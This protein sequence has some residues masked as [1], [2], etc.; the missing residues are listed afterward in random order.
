MAN[1]NNLVVVSDLHIGCKLGLC[2]PDG[3]EMDEGGQYAPS[4]VQRIVYTYWD[5]FWGKWVPDQVQGQD[6]DVL[7]NGDAINGTPH[8]AVSNWTNNREFQRRHAEKILGP[9]AERARR[10]FMV[11]GTEAHVGKSAQEEETLATNLKAVANDVGQ[12]ARYEAW[13]RVG[14]SRGGLVHAM[15]HIGTTGSSH[16][17]STAVMKELNEAYVEAGRWGDEAPRVVVRSHRHRNLQVRI[18]S[19]DGAAISCVTAGWQ[20]KTPFTYR[21]AGGRQAQPQIGG[22][23][24]RYHRNEL[25]VV[26]K[27]WRI[28]RPKEE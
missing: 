12:R 15:H 5:E 27:T 13:I 25:Y 1:L 17:E 16:Y 4:Q 18:P 24:V 9:V 28:E 6:F 10:F 7:V 19:K 20:L 23:L 11:R 2:H 26:D 8:Q 3:A 14:G 21:V 22:V